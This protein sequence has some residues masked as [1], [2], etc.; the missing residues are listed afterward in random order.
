MRRM[1]FLLA[2]LV[3]LPSAVHGVEPDEMLADAGQE[4][5]AR[6][7]GRQLRCLVCQGEDIDSS[8]AELA[9]DLRLLVRARIAAGDTDAAVIDFVRDRYGDYVLMT[10]PVQGN[11]WLLWSMPAVVFLGGVAALAFF[12]RGQR[13]SLPDGRAGHEGED[14]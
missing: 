11:T 10:P 14:A 6:E 1:L 12:L 5:R 2:I 7:I 8:N 9:R 13:G 4:M 3:F